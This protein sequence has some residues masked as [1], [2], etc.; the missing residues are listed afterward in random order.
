MLIKLP[1]EVLLPFFCSCFFTCTATIGYAQTSRFKN[2]GA[3]KL[4]KCIIEGIKSNH[5]NIAKYLIDAPAFDPLHPDDLNMFNLPHSPEW[6]V[7]KPA[8]N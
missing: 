4:A 8:G 3:Y 6:T 1:S 7:V 2:Y 5:L